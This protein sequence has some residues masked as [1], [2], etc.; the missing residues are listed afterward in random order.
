MV[1]A[2]RRSVLGAGGVA[3]LLPIGLAMGVLLTSAL[4]GTH[5]L[6]ALSQ[7]FAGPVVPGGR[8]GSPTP[9]LESS[10]QVPQV[11]PASRA[12]ARAA[13]AARASAPGAAALRPGTGTPGG[14]PG[15]GTPHTPTP[16]GRG[17]GTGGGGAPRPGGTSGTPPPAPAPAPASGPAH[18]AG[19]QAVDA[20]RQT[21]PAAA[22]V[23]DAAQTVVDLLP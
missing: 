8:G 13:R 22:P 4:G 3:L 16:T 21:A 7:V 6:S 14:R 23:A 5:A 12:A 19:Q 11:P 20:V 1:A 10:R 9:G 17:P 18:Q 2:W 15:A